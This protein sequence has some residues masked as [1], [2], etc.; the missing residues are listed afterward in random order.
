[1]DES[2]EKKDDILDDSNTKVS[3][4]EGLEGN[5]DNSL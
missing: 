4:D 1:V 3:D 5:A 2:D